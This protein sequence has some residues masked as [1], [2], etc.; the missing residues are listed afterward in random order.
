MSKRPASEPPTWRWIVT[1]VIDEREVLRADAARPSRRARRPSAGRGCVSVS[2]RLNS[3]LAGRLALV[4]DRLDPLAEAVPGLQR[5]GERDQQVGQLVL[6]RRR[7]ACCALK[8]D[9]SRSARR[10]AGDDRERGSASGE[11]PATR[12]DEPER[13]ARTPSADVDELDRAQRQVGALEQ[14]LRAP[15][16][17]FDVGRRRARSPRTSSGAARD[18]LCAALR[19]RLRFC[20]RRG[21]ARAGAAAAS[22][23]AARHDEEPHASRT[24]RPT[25]VARRARGAERE[26]RLE[27]RASTPG[28]RCRSP[29]AGHDE[30]TSARPRDGGGERELLAGPGR[31]QRSSSCQVRRSS[32]AIA[33]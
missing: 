31:G 18:A 6:E 22:P 5:R 29:S 20:A 7:A 24:S 9:D 4:D 13:R 14:P 16:H 3:L 21:A 26:R 19:A 1:A 32:V 28:R 8:H 15:C 25:T 2:T 23:R 27:Q 33:A 12:E 11:A 10:A 30:P 17:C